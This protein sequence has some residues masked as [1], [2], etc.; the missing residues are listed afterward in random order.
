MCDPLLRLSAASGPPLLCP[1]G[2]PCPVTFPGARLKSPE[3]G[4]VLWGSVSV[5]M[6]GVEEFGAL[7]LRAV[8]PLPLSS[9]GNRPV[10][11]VTGR[12]AVLAV[13]ALILDLSAQVEK[14]APTLLSGLSPGG[15]VPGFVCSRGDKPPAP[16][17]RKGTAGTRRDTLP[18]S[19]R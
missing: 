7:C 6:M 5:G 9:E 19:P 13:R 14:F 4:P 10:T 3:P 2:G 17:A 16:V 8:F 1:P 18:S 12:L 11:G 15:T